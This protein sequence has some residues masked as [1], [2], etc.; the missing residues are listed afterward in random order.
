ML[1]AE[2]VKPYAEVMMVTDKQLQINPL[3]T[4]SL[5][6][7]FDKILPEHVLPAV[8]QVISSSEKKI[9]ELESLAKP[10]W[11][12]LMIPLEKISKEIHCVISP[13]SHLKGV[14]DS[15]ELRNIWPPAQEKLVHFSLR[16]KQSPKLYLAMKNLRDLQKDSLSAVQLRILD[17]A[18]LDAELSGIALEGTK[19][20]RFN[21]IQ[22]E[23]V[24]LQTTFSNNVLDATKSYFLVITD[25]AVMEGLPAHVLQTSSAEYNRRHKDSAISTAENGPW[26]LTL[27]PTIYLPVMMQCKDRSVREQIY[28]AQ[29]ARASVG[30][31]DNGPIIEKILSLRKESANLLGFKSFAELSIARK[32]AP[33]VDHVTKLLND[34]K[35]AS[36][37]QSKKEIESLQKLA[38]E[39][40]QKE[41]LAHFD[42]MFYAERLKERRFEFKEEEIK[43]YL[44]FP[45]VLDGLF[46][47]AEK[48]FEIKVRQAPVQ[49]AVWHSDVRYYLVENKKGEQIAGFYLDPYSRPA[50]KRGGAWM[51]NCVDRM[52]LDGK[53]QLPVAYIICNGTPPSG[54]KPSL[55][56][57]GEM[58]TLFHEFGHGLQHMLTKIEHLDASGI[59]GVEWDAV[60]LPSQFMENWCYHKPTLMEMTAHVDTG[61][62]LPEAYFNKLLAART[63]M[64]GSQMLRQVRASLADIDLHHT[65]DPNGKLSALERFQQLSKDLSVLEPLKEDRFLCAFSH[66]FAGGYSAGYYSYKWAEVLSA[67]AFAA[68]EEADLSNEKAMHDIG[69]RFR[70]TVLELGGGTPPMEVF[71]LFRGREP[72]VKALLR[73]NGLTP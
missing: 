39:M 47:L 59:N 57:F 40:G 31:N 10:T 50:T 63:F 64:S 5:L 6:P 38:V 54:G 3:L 61:E 67:D 46:A 48:L 43:P 23:F 9:A 56:T 27:D 51:D 58:T 71:K 62:K 8:E 42:T 70:E 69:M 36:F 20:E 53:L 17:Q 26:A 72:D 37:E 18:I 41:P 28:M 65:F 73:H 11:E 60:E 29:I 12:T 16:I 1:D 44:Q 4:G 55:M 32:M 13:I 34:L 35:E 24:Q 68:F 2:N 21:A 52:R 19:K 33:S 22:Q 66:I 15:E 7:Q 30:K 25:K 45:K 14:A 49:P